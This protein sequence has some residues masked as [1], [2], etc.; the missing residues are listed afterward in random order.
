VA[1]SVEKP[2]FRNHSKNSR[3]AEAWLLLVRGGPFDLLLRAP[4][5]LLTNALTIRRTN[6]Q[7]Q[8]T[9]PKIRGHWS[10]S[11]E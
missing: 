2:L 11:T 8:R 4:K 10:F 1:Y 7:L 6:R 5:R 3:L 9:H